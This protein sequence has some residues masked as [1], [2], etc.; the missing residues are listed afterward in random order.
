MVASSSIALIGSS[1]VGDPTLTSTSDGRVTVG[2]FVVEKVK[3]KDRA[4]VALSVREVLILLMSAP[5]E[6]LLTL[7]NCN[8]ES[9]S[10]LT[11]L[12]E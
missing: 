9:D 8:S 6:E 2:G 11:E 7:S 10:I 12:K 5:T 1:I 4:M 3:T